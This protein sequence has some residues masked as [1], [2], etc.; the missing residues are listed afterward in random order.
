[1]SAVQSQIRSRGFSAWEVDNRNQAALNATPAGVNQIFAKTFSS[2][3]GAVRLTGRVRLRPL[4]PALGIGRQQFGC[5]AG[6]R[7]LGQRIAKPAQ[8]TALPIVPPARAY[9]GADR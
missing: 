1:V 5:L 3:D 6:E 4:V 9:T 8:L 2:A 7:H